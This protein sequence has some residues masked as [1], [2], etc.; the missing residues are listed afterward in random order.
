MQTCNIATLNL[1]RISRLLL[2]VLAIGAA[3]TATWA[4]AA[5]AQ[6]SPETA[7]LAKEIDKSLRA[8]ERDMF[9][10]KNESADLQLNGIAPQIEQL[11]AADPGNQKLGALESKYSQI[12]K[13][14][15]R[16]LGRTA[17]TTSSSAPAA[18]PK[19]AT[20][21]PSMAA[22]G[23]ATTEESSQPQLPRAIQSDMANARAKLD[24]AES[25]WAK[26][27]TGGRTV[28]GSSDPNEVKL[29]AVEQPFK[30]ATYYYGNILKKCSS[31]SS[32]CDPDHPEIAALKSR[33]EAMQA[34]VD[35]LNAEIASAAAA[36]ARK[37]A[38]EAAQA[39]AAEADCEGWNQRLQV[40]TEGDKALYRCVS[41]EATEMP[42]CKNNFDEAAALM[43]EFGKTPWAQ[44]P[45]GALHSTLSD[46]N[47][48][49]ENFQSSYE[50]YAA[51]Q[52]A[53]R[54]NMGEI[55]FSR[56]P[57]NPDNP[58][59]LTTE[60]NAGDRIY[61]LIRTTKPWSAIY[62]N[63][64]GVDVM[65]NVELDGEKAHAQFVKLKSPGL[66]AQ[67]YLIFEVAPDPDKM[68]AY[69]DPDREY[70]SSTATMRQGPNELTNLLAQLKPGRHTM[71]FDVT[72]FG[73]V[74]SAGSFTVSGD[75]FQS[76]SRL[77]D[78]IAEGVAQAVTL[79]AARMTN[80]TL[81]AGM[82]SL[83]ENAGWENIHRINI[84]DKDWWID[85]VSGGDSP[86]KSRHLAAAALAR[87]GDGYYYKVCTFHQ[88]QLLG[89]GF[90]ELYL[91]HQGERVP[92][93]KANIDK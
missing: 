3:V 74:W 73:T 17:A 83:L 22:P 66:L 54:A 2:L 65:V 55:I 6:P 59:N 30:S 8:A 67:Q 28:G 44:E 33:I 43:A 51:D 20:T 91:S 47:R 4:P 24:E 69:A 60:F 85:R 1:L 27:Y 25:Y 50:S 5:F 12:R 48:Y 46:L 82:R 64:D 41:A 37:E 21:A 57:I 92:V 62:G 52:A 93:P 36:S 10:G 81:A 89:G 78:A 26:D 42:G 9:N 19:P 63:K 39:Q 68:T 34:N 56:D 35:G 16:K 15:D 71:A 87:D 61:G 14:L 77:H 49:M 76:Y 31:K 23:S 88:D 7:N 45:C 32:P 70:G 29:E 58:S 79:P 38:A 80:N 84:V 40:Y 18:A 13:N 86:V 11:K 53:A 72:S 90:G 75:D